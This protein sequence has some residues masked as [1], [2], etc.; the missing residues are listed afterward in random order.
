MKVQKEKDNSRNGR[1]I[2]SI[3]TI[4]SLLMLVAS[5]CAT[6]DISD[7]YGQ[8]E[9]T[10][11]TISSE[12]SGKLLQFTPT[13][14][15]NI[16][17]DRQV[18]Y[19]DST[20]LSLQKKELEAQ[21]E[22]IRARITNINAEVEVQQAELSLAETNL[23]R[24]Q[25]LQKDG[26]TTQQKLD[27][28]EARVRTI[29]K[30]INALQTQKQSVRAE[31]N[32]TQAR[33]EQVNDQIADALIINPVNGTVLTTFVEPYEL[34]QRGQPLY[35]IANLDTLILRVYVD[36]AQL[37]SVK[38]GQQVEVLVD[39]NAEENQSMRGRVSW[40]ASEAEFTPEQIQTKEE[41]VTQVYA[42]KVRVPNHD[43]TL[44]IGMPGEVN[45]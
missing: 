38:L 29:Q 42:V 21:L 14:G 45:F 22:S 26:A 20:R 32:A 4:L 39:K 12:M 33:I 40:I 27:D 30:R 28:A 35:R 34:V 25:A 15:D 5:G 24:L 17:A 3:F 13:E 44:K 19:V 36:G 43:S 10:E 8:F 16:Q 2:P 7:A 18:G 11:T 41:R 6:N 31:I 1:R 9:A 37:P 23:N